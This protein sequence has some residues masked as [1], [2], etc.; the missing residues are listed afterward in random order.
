M[1]EC[2]LYKHTVMYIVGGSFPYPAFILNGV[3]KHQQ[4]ETHPLELTVQ[5]TYLKLMNVQCE[6]KIN[7]LAIMVHFIMEDHLY[8]IEYF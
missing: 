4:R 1:W 6:I 7:N 5:G 3:R 2:Q 8:I